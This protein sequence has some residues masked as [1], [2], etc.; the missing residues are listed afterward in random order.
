[1]RCS[2]YFDLTA[3]YQVPKVTVAYLV[4]MAGCLISLPFL[5][6]TAPNWY[7][8]R[9]LVKVGPIAAF[10][11]G[12]WFTMYSFV[13]NYSEYR[14]LMTLYNLDFSHE[15]IGEVVDHSPYDPQHGKIYES[16]RVNGIEFV[17]FPT[18]FHAGFQR[19][20]S[21]GSPISNGQIV[22]IRYVNGQIIRLDICDRLDSRDPARQP[23]PDDLL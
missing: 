8:Y 17:Y 5:R 11:V 2:L 21:E 3:G 12:L 15:V 1:M 4:M 19:A 23:P 20:S 10:C 7:I 6:M 14:Y 22:S 13:E 16:F 9:L 18:E